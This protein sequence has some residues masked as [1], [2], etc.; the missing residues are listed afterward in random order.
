MRQFS[1]ILILIIS[2][3][4][5]NLKTAKDYIADAEKLSEQEKYKEAINKAI[6]AILK[7]FIKEVEIYTQ[8]GWIVKQS[9]EILIE[10]A[11]Y[12]IEHL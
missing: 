7:S 10:D 2:L 6:T 9:S 5:C 1:T 3:T 12:I 8:K 4:S 11:R